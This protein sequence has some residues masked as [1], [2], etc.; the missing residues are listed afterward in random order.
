[1]LIP[2]Y[3]GRIG[4]K[5]LAR[6][7]RLLETRCRIVKELEAV[8][9]PAHLRCLNSVLAPSNL[10]KSPR[11]PSQ[12]FKLPEPVLFVPLNLPRAFQEGNK[13]RA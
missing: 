12:I 4:L 13:V 2:T 3:F 5:F 10:R 9:I 7:E 6:L 1:M 8:N 11:I